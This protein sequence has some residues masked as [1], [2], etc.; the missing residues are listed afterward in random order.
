M[1]LFTCQGHGVCGAEGVWREQGFQL[2]DTILQGGPGV[3]GS[4]VA[5]SAIAEG[6]REQGTCSKTTQST[7]HF[8]LN[9]VVIVPV[10]ATTGKRRA[11]RKCSKIRVKLR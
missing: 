2:L 11:G 6:I 5:I 8:T 7:L 4:A 10:A 9:P 1:G 3:P